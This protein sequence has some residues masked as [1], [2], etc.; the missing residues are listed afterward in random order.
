MNRYASDRSA[1]GKPIRDFGQIQKHIG[2]S[3]A[4]YRAMR[5][6]IY[7]TA[8]N[9]V[10]GKAGHRLDSDGVKLFAATAAKEIADS[11]IQVMG[12]Y[13]YVAEYQWSDFGA[14]QII[15]DWWRNRR[16]SSKEHCQRFTKIS[17][18][19]YS[20]ISISSLIETNFLVDCHT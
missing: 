7:D 1:F 12:G 2:D 19:N 11:A 14:T 20:I 17:R 13:G 9:M 18:I 6:Y 5:S 15:G 10:L 3:W 16:I 4:K 8:A